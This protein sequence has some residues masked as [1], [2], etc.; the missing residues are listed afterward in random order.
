MFDV[1]QPGDAAWDETTAYIQETYARTYGAR[2]DTFMPKIM[3]VTSAAGDY[4]AVMGFR[5][6]AQERLFLE[7][8]LDDSIE[9]VISRYLGKPVKR[10]EIIEVGNLAEAEP[11]DARM[12]LIGGTAYMWALGCRWLVF[13]GVSRMRNSFRRL[14]LDIW[15][16]MAADENM[17]PP[18]EV[19]KWGTYYNAHPVVCFGD[20]KQGHDNLQELWASLRDTWAAAE[21]AGLKDAA[22]LPGNTDGAND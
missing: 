20:I 19:A 22:A 16:L 18:E 6:A 10:S 1:I 8:Y 14:G 15:E 13:T 21:E 3:R 12:A 7:N 2:I 4:R 9:D 17:L 5:M 11:G